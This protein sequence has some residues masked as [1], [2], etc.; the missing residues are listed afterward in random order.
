MLAAHPGC[1]H[2]TTLV[3]QDAARYGLCDDC[4]GAGP[5][6]E[7]DASQAAAILGRKGG[8][9]KGAS[10]VRG[11]SAYYRGIRAK[12]RDVAVSTVE[13]SKPWPR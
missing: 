4:F 13:G 11:D 5:C 6:P 12:R 1:E 9:T 7:C 10:K 8:R 2:L 3:P